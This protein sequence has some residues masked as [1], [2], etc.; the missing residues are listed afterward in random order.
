MK[1]KY[2][3][4]Y[5]LLIT[6]VFLVLATKLHAQR[7][8]TGDCIGAIPV[9]DDYYFQP[10]T[11]YGEGDFP[12]EI[13]STSQCPYDCL[14]GENNSTWY[15]F[16]IQSGGLLSFVISPVDSLDDYDWAVYKITPFFGCEDIYDN[17]AQMVVSCNS[18]GGDDW[19]WWGDTGALDGPS[20]CS[21]PGESGSKW[22]LDI[23]VNAGEEYVLY[24][25]DWTQTAPGYSL[26][27]S[28]STA[29]IYDTV[30][31]EFS[32]VYSTL[33][34]CGSDSIDIRFSENVTCSSVLNAT[35]MTITG[36]DGAHEIVDITSE[37]C[38]QADYGSLY[39]FKV[40]PPFTVNGDYILEYEIV[41]GCA[42]KDIC[43]N[44]AL[45]QDVFFSLD[46]DAPDID[47][48]DTTII[49][50]SCGQPDGEITGIEVSGNGS[51]DFYWLNAAGDTVG[52]QEDLTG[53]PAGQY[54]FY[55]YDQGGCHSMEGPFTIPDAG[56]PE[57]IEANMNISDNTC[58]QSNGAITGLQIEGSGPFDYEWTDGSG[59]FVSDMLDLTGLTGGN[60]TLK[61]TDDNGC[62]SFSDSYMIEDFESPVINTM[63][64]L[65]T[66]ENCGMQNGS[67]T[68]IMVNG[69]SS[70]QYR[71]YNAAGDT[72]G[73]S[74]N[75]NNGA[76][77][78]YYLLVRD[79]N[80]CETTSGPYNIY[81]IPGPQID[82][83]G[84]QLQD[85]SCGLAN[86]SISGIEFTGSSGL[87]YTWYNAAGDTVG[88][89]SV[90]TDV[91]PGTYTIEVKDAATCLSEAGP[92]TINNV[93]GATVSNILPTAPSCELNNGRIEINAQGG[94]GNR[95]FSIDG[96][97]TW[98]ANSVFD[99]LGPGD[100]NVWVRDDAG[101]EN[102]YGQNPVNLVNEGE[103]ITAT[104][105]ATTPSCT[106]DD[107]E[108]SVG[109]SADE[110]HWTG[111]L[112]FESYEQDPVIE[113]VEQQHSGIYT[114]V[115]TENTYGC[116]DTTSV[117]VEVIESFEV[118]V[119]ITASKNPIYPGE[120]ITLTANGDWGAYGATYNWYI[121]DVLVQSNQDSVLVTDDIFGDSEVSCIA[122][123]EA[124][125]ALP[126][127]VESDPLLI[128]VF[129]IVFYLPNSFRPESTQGNNEFKI[130]AETTSIPA[131]EMMI[132]DRWGKQIFSSRDPDKGWD[133]TVNG[134]PAPAGTYAWVVTYKVYDDASRA[135]R[136][137]LK[138]GTLTLIR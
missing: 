43:D 118:M 49:P 99:S 100:Y 92:F 82:L 1:K 31:P 77:G 4:I 70:L 33:V 96:G 61:V 48:S 87:T 128:D 94:S 29:Q 37:T 69:S 24:I 103:A 124:K 16:T 17:A 131:F 98:V 44:I 32:T 113:N 28:P 137:E 41:L 35:C 76:S 8:T 123:I 56:A 19:A 67:V 21:G 47:V 5:L 22:N 111:P 27:F 112:G 14:D 30:R 53:Q 50:S 45:S 91:Y 115:L 85:A 2:T 125:C 117:E 127:P 18:V 106:G 93:E 101:C 102:E 60:Y 9:C 36:P 59:N 26:D 132:Y 122:S 13:R 58:G 95:E 46:L 107:L 97:N 68:G 84:I 40:D 116:T 73:T 104:A 126:N 74:I 34:Q 57:I 62:Q 65:I 90:L 39:T 3:S 12:N 64:T 81:D 7:A 105:E 120:E 52:Y 121:E 135:G 83:S 110:Y 134:K 114:L 80:G 42:V 55:A 129:D 138:K 63:D 72:V 130:L 51:L 38:E 23:P 79:A 6:F 54:T 89:D 11:A 119:G 75:L 71:W 133:G 88:N 78:T 10:N 136:E 109:F 66:G 108:L 20:D 86:G 25:S 15:N